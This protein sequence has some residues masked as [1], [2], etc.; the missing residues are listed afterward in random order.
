MI[1]LLIKT[2][3]QI[4]IGYKIQVI[5]VSSMAVRAYVAATAYRVYILSQLFVASCYQTLN[6]THVIDPH[7]RLWYCRHEPWR[8]AGK[9]VCLLM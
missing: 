7:L 1:C 6:L 5:K 3:C 9:S 4:L 8:H 2:V